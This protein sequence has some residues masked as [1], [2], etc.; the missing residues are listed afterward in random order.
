MVR[1]MT[2][3]REMERVVFDVSGYAPQ[4]G[5]EKKER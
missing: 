5:F 4:V 2:L 1:V 3:E